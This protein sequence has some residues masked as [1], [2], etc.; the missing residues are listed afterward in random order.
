MRSTKNVKYGKRVKSSIKSGQTH[1]L[2]PD[3]VVEVRR[4]GNKSVRIDDFYGIQL[5]IKIVK[6]PEWM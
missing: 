3:D 2:D 4:I 5:P 6:R 1:V